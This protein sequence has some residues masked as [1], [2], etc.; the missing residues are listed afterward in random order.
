MGKSSA[1]PVFLHQEVIDFFRKLIKPGDL[2]IDIGANTGGITVPMALAAGKDGLTLA[3]E[4]NPLAF[5]VLT[6]NTVLN[7]HI[8]NI[9]P[10]NF[11]ISRKEDEFFY[12]SSETSFANGGISNIKRGKHG[13]YVHSEKINGI[14]LYDFLKKRYP[15]WLNKLSL[16][17]IDTERYDK[18]ILKSISGLVR[19]YKPEIIAE[20]FG[21]N[22]DEEVM[23][24]YEVLDGMDYHI[25]HVSDFVDN[26]SMT[27]I[28]NAV[29]MTPW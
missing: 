5:Q 17:K 26:C 20:S 9:E 23:E 13:K 6:D 3:F 27:R 25:F 14:Q 19:K 11:A 18:E 28:E 8:T 22:S 1:I 16:I 12:I 2:I 4:S 24:L 7:D 15:E 29:E 10:Y 21:K